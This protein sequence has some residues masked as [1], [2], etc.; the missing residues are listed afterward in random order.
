MKR[1]HNVLHLS[2]VCFLTVIVFLYQY[3]FTVFRA[4]TKSCSTLPFKI[5]LRRIILTVAPYICIPYVQ[6]FIITINQHT[7]HSGR[8]N[9]L[10]ERLG[11][12]K[13]YFPGGYFIVISSL[14]LL[15]FPRPRVTPMT[16]QKVNTTIAKGP[17]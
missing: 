4:C 16:Q 3:R 11:S 6:Q 17:R 9:H 12:G 2:K 8:E 5:S 7:L 13:C 1:G 10:Q 15:A 14:P